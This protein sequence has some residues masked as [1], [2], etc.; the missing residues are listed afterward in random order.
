MRAAPGSVPAS[1][2]SSVVLLSSEH[3]EPMHDGAEFA[4]RRRSDALGRRVRCDELGIFRFERAQAI[5]QFVVFAVG[6]FGI[7]ENVAAVVVVV[8]RRA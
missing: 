6:Y 2:S 4:L 1:I 3:R 8:D 7:V 5:E